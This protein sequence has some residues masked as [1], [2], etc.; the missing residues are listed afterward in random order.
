MFPI[1]YIFISVISTNY[2]SPLHFSQAA[3]MILVFMEAPYS[4]RNSFCNPQNM[5]FWHCNATVG[6]QVIPRSGILFWEGTKGDS[7][8]R[9]FKIQRRVVTVLAGVS[10]R[11]S[12][13]QLFKDL[14]ILT[15]AS[16][17]ILE[18]T[19]FIRKY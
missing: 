6:T 10:S 3:A 5:P 15:M 14:N 18:V 4:C 16:L 13:R 11:T 19:C 8:S 7:S 2:N 12:Y 17:Y 1:T 9:V